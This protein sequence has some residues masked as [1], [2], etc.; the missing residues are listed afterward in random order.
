MWNARQIRVLSENNLRDRRSCPYWGVRSF[1]SNFDANRLQ[2]RQPKTEYFFS[3]VSLSA[4]IFGGIRPSGFCSGAWFSSSRTCPPVSNGM[5]IV[6]SHAPSLVSALWQSR[7]RLATNLTQM[8]RAFVASRRPVPAI[9]D[10]TRNSS[11]G[12]VQL[13]EGQ[14]EECDGQ[15]HVNSLV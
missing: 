5:Q 6:E 14:V 9:S 15:L 12:S 10:H 7:Q 8:F 11:S 2:Y 13:R 1:S 3:F 4:R